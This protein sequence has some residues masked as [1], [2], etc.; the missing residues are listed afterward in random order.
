MVFNTT[1]NNMS[2]ILWLSVLLVE[3]QEKITDKLYN[4]LLH[5]VHL[6]KAAFEL[7]TLEWI[8]T[9]CTCSC[10]SNDHTIT[11]MT[12]PSEYIYNILS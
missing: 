4:I 9:D 11:T 12:A 7:T 3:N 10:K 1:F 8:D 6:S 5:R 2:V